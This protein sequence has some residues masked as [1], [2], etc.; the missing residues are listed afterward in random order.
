MEANCRTRG[1]RRWEEE[2][3][4]TEVEEWGEGGGGRKERRRGREQ[5]RKERRRGGSG[6][7]GKEEE[8]GKQ[9]EGMERIVDGRKGRGRNRYKL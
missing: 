2:G 8:E 7:E 6:G 3:G 5:G 1:E 9:G 4:K